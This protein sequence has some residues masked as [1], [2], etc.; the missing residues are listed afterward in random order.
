MGAR[1]SRSQDIVFA[2]VATLLCELA[3]DSCGP[4]GNS[5]APAICDASARTE[6]LNVTLDPWTPSTPFTLKPGTTGWLQLTKLP[7]ADE[8]LFGGTAGAGEVYSLRSG[9]EPNITTKPNG[10]KE[11]HDPSITIDK[12]LTWQQMP[13]GPGDWELYSFSN[14]GIEVVSCPAS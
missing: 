12:A 1:P 4:I 14:P 6:L 13:L 10:D 7:Q 8:G 5:T 3:L 2:V 11:P 9:A